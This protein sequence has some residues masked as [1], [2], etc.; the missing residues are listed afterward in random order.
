MRNALAI[1]VVL[2]G[3]QIQVAHAGPTRSGFLIGA[4]LGGGG[5]G[6][7]T[8]CEDVGGGLFELHVGGWLNP[9][10]AIA[11]E[12]WGVFG[13]PTKLET[14]AFQ[15]FALGTATRRLAPRLWVKGGVGV[16]MFSPRE[17]IVDELT[18]ERHEM[19][20]GLGL[21][22][23]LGYEL[24]QSRGSFVVDVSGRVGVGLFPDHGRSVVGG[25]G[26]GVT[27]N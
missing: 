27:W 1:V 14:P 3:A 11:Y 13:D 19:L 4:S 8:G 21:S 24:H 10:W 9:R 12:A 18:G 6:G 25:L 7:C 17:T 2:L 15:G 16:A 22:S 20:R 23:G 5:G 26:I